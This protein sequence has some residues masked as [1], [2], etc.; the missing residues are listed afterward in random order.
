MIQYLYVFR[1]IFKVYWKYEFNIKKWKRKFIFICLYLCC[2]FFFVF[3]FSFYVEK[4]SL[5]FIFCVISEV[6]FNTR[7]AAV[8]DAENVPKIHS[9]APYFPNCDPADIDA[10]ILVYPFESGIDVRSF[11]QSSVPL[12]IECL[13]GG[14]II[15]PLLDENSSTHKTTESLETNQA[16]QSSTV[17]V[18][19]SKVEEVPASQVENDQNVNDSGI[20]GSLQQEEKIIEKDLDV[21]EE[22]GSAVLTENEESKNDSVQAAVEA[23]ILVESEIAKIEN[24]VVSGESEPTEQVIESPSPKV[25]NFE[26]K[27]VA[28]LYE[29]KEEIATFPEEF[30]LPEEQVG[31]ETSKESLETPTEELLSTEIINSKEEVEMEPFKETSETAVEVETITSKEEV[32]I[33]PSKEKSET[34]V[35]VEIVTSKEEVRMEPSQEVSETVVGVEIVTTKEEV[36]IEPSKETSETDVEVEIIT[37]KEELEREPSTEISEIAV[38]VETA[39]EVVEIEPSL[40]TSETVIKAEI[41]TSKEEVE[42]EPSKESDLA[43]P[44]QVETSKEESLVDATQPEPPSEESTAVPVIV[45]TSKEEIISSEKYIPIPVQVGTSEEEGVIVPIQVETSKKETP[46]APVEVEI[47]IAQEIRVIVA[48]KDVTTQNAIRPAVQADASIEALAILPKRLAL[49][50]FLVF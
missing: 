8:I 37:T 5:F 41:V 39:K 1:R 43:I 27:W 47:P 44:V 4:H 38:E 7:A 9:Q 20:D 29:P 11:S 48:R 33:E 2:C 24:A 31:L 10:S 32:E 50:R 45:E 22:L 19:V 25:P 42:M 14:K 3:F 18:E 26:E 49:W 30:D 34:A 23:Q 36:V 46:P 21:A 16:V 6:V 12:E 28:V 13:Q 17:L 15:I 35:D 40:E